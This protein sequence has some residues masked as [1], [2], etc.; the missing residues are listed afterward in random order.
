M[1]E[2]SPLSL[3]R[4]D[5]KLRLRVPDDRFTV[6]F[7]GRL[8]RRKGWADFLDAMQ[9]VTAHHDAYFLIAGEGHERALVEQRINTLRLQD[10]GRLLGQ[11]SSMGDFYRALDCFVMSSRWEPHGLTQLEAQRA[12]VPVVVSNVPGLRDTVRDGIDALLFEPGNALDLAE[13]IERI[14]TDGE[15]R[16]ALSKGGRANADRFSIEDFEQAVTRVYDL[17]CNHQYQSVSE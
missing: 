3:S 15:L 1:L 13:K 6:G 10:R 16:A 8:V 2:Q 7:A 5:A 9:K 12:A 11:V 17:A 14:A 4:Y